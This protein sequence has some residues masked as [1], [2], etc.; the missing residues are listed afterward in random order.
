MCTRYMVSVSA[1]GTTVSASASPMTAV[2]LSAPV[3]GRTLLY[4]VVVVAIE[5]ALPMVALVKRLKFLPARFSTL[6][7]AGKM[8]VV[9]MPKR[10]TMETVRVMLLL[11]V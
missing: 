4:V 9:T 1:T 11:L 2:V 10:K 8:S 7:R 3:F 5:E 6:L